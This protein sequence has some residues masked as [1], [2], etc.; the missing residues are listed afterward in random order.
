MSKKNKKI[1][2]MKQHMVRTLSAQVPKSH[3][4]WKTHR[5]W[6]TYRKWRKRV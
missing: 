5:T 1:K 6:D 2:L 3:S 4:V